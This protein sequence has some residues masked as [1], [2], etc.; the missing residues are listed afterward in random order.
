MSALDI[1][2]VAVAVASSALA[3]VRWLR[4]AQREHYL[5]GSVTRFALRWWFGAVSFNRLLS[6]VAVLGFL[7]ALSFH[8]AGIAPAVVVAIGPVGLSLRGRT[9]KLAWTRRL[10]TLA[11]VWA[12]L[13]AVV[14]AAGV[15]GGVGAVVAVAGALLVPVLVDAACALT[16]PLERR[17]ADRFVESASA[18][19]R[20][21]APTVVAITG[22]YG[23][24]STK[25]YVGHLL[26]STRAVVVSP[27][28]YNNRA[29]LARTVNQHLAPG[30]EVLVAEMGT[31][32]RG[33]IAEM[34]SWLTPRVGVIT[35]IGPVHLERFG[36]EERIVEAKAEILERA[37]TAVLNVDDPRL[38]AVADRAEAAG[39]RVWRCSSSDRHADVCVLS[40]GAAVELHRRGALVARVDAAD[41]RPTNVACA[42]AVAL[43]LGVPEAEVVRLLPTLPGAPNRL[44]V[45]AGSAGI[46]VVDDTYN[47]NPAGSRVALEVMGRHAREGHRRVV[48]TPGMVELGDRQHPENVAFASAA[49]A[50]A[51]DLVIVGFTNRKALLEGAGEQNVTISGW[52]AGAGGYTIAPDDDDEEDEEGDEDA[53]VTATGASRG[54]E[55]VA[56]AGGSGGGQTKVDGAPPDHAARV[57][58]VGSRD[59]AV[60]WVRAHLGEGDVVLYENDLPDHF[61]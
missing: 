27:A 23:K 41:A 52:R 50:V 15:L 45:A 24:T 1:A 22:S 43:E 53:G 26:A 59:E 14:V 35:A 40:A 61:A 5:A 58:L 20:R 4:V 32:G 37:D 44:T 11:V 54:G 12:A 55:G 13:Q 38:R 29:G 17:L 10:R 31:Y 9:A 47:S 36:S 56:S 2:V 60:S 46:T 48:V 57:V 7:V 28:S 51:T 8:P 3:G 16:A 18:K 39:K 30:T 42:A 49:R 6:F 19:L 33:E 21:L 25:G 34:C